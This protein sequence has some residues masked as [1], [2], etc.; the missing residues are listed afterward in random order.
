MKTRINSLLRMVGLV[1]LIGNFS[2]CSRLAGN[3]QYRELYRT[4]S[5]DSQVEALVLTGDAGATTSTA[6][7]VLI[8]PIGKVVDTNNPPQSD[9]VFRGDHI[10]GLNLVWRKSQLLEIGYQ[11]A[12]ISEFKNLWE[13]WEGRKFSY[14]VEVRLAPASADFSVPLEDR[15]P[16]DLK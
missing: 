5:P 12:R 16:Y 13:I 4:K 11:L 2:G 3:W 15:M 14:S 7:L 1:V 9:V 10:K 6:T 8:V